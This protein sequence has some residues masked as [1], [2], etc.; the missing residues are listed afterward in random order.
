MSVHAAAA[1]GGMVRRGDGIRAEVRATLALT[2]PLALTQLGQIA[3]M[4]TDLIMIG[5]L[6]DS[7]LAAASVGGVV[8]FTGFVLV[9][10]IVMA[11]AP[12]SAQAFG[13]RRARQVRRVIRQGLWIVLFLSAPVFAVMMHASD[14]LVAL[15]QP[16]D[17][18]ARAQP[19]VNAIF[20]ALPFG[21]SFI[22]LRGFMASINRPNPAIWVVLAA[23]PLNA[24]FNYALIFGEFGLPAL[25]LLGA[26]LA[27]SLVNGLMV[28]A[29]VAIVVWR[30]PYRKYNLFGRFW[31]PDWRIFGRIFV[32]GLPIAVMFLMEYG[33]FAAAVMLMGRIGEQAVAAHQIAL[34]IAAVTFMVPFGISQAA[35]VRVGHAV[36]RRDGAGARR[37]G[38]IGISLGVAFMSLTSLLFLAVP[39]TLVGVFLDPT[40]PSSGPVLALAAQ[41]LLIAAAFQLADGAQAIGAGALRGLND[42]A[43][44]MVFTILAYWG[45]GFGLAWWLGDESR[46]GPHGI[47]IGLAVGLGVAAVCHLTRFGLLMRHGALPRSARAPG[48]AAPM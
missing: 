28:A 32:V 47:W 25:G 42:T 33:V 1:P 3:M 30:R 4:T 7:F 29:M 45:A 34:Q 20:A 41:L 26:G 36:G 22:V 23:I 46:L 10:G 27:T 14:I 19:Y 6:G 48:G 21:A 9:M 2:G 35:T 11:T 40:K 12:L 13:A 18:A 38:W 16:P 43:V 24:L 15:G 37:A 31:R 44:P 17:L 39:E 5:R 8:F